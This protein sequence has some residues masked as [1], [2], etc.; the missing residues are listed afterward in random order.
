MADQVDLESGFGI[1]MENYFSRLPLDDSPPLI[2]VDD[3]G[4]GLDLSDAEAFIIRNKVD[5]FLDKGFSIGEN[6]TALAHSNMFVGNRSALTAK[7]SSKVYVLDNQFIEND[8][9]LELYQKKQFFSPPSIYSL[10][11]PALK[12][13]IVKTKASQFFRTATRLNIEDYIGER[14]FF[15]AV[16]GNNWVEYE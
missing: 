16:E 2:G 5:F 6:T 8:I 11:F 10:D 1:V 3:N 4:D 12:Y 7:D 13:K 14:S 9:D 15:S